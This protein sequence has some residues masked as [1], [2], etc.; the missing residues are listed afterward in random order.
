MLQCAGS[1][2]PDHLDYCSRV[3][4]NQAVKNAIRFKEMHPGGRVDILYRDM[5]CY[6][7]GELYY[8][9]ARLSG[10]NFI[11][12]DPQENPADIRADDQGIEIR[13]IDPSIGR[14]VTILPDLLVLSTGIKSRD[15]EELASMLRIPR[16]SAGFFIEAH[17]K[18]RPVDLP[19]EGLYMAGT[20][21]A[22]KDISETIAQAQAAV[23]RATTVLSKKSLKLS[24]VVSTVDPAHCAVCLTCV[25]ACPY[26]VPF[27]NDQHTAE[28]N[29]ALCQGCGICVAECP[30]KAITLGRYLDS[31]IVA[32]LTA[33]TEHETASAEGG[34]V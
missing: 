25:R 9:K 13:V 32:K 31:N 5:R 15:T 10:I 29:P 28:I 19:S 12:F 23:A 4:C 16:N 33:Y 17:A 3:C 14:A 6:G 11:R 7:T 22:P 20:A 26:G 8:R 24:G 2:D 34:Q 30:A 18:L 1:R 21:H 27:I